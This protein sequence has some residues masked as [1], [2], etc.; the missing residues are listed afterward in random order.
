MILVS[1]WGMPV[2]REPITNRFFTYQGGVPTPDSLYIGTDTNNEIF[3]LGTSTSINPDGISINKNKDG[4][5]ISSEK[6]GDSDV[7]FGK[8]QS[9]DEKEEWIILFT[10]NDE[11]FDYF[12]F[13]IWRDDMYTDRTNEAWGV[14]LYGDNQRRAELP[15]T[16][17]ATYEG[18]S[19]GLYTNADESSESAYRLYLTTSDIS[20]EVDFLNDSALL[21]S[22]NTIGFDFDD[23][24]ASI[25][26]SELDFTDA[27]LFRDG[28]AS[29]RWQEGQCLMTAFCAYGGLSMSYYGEEFDNAEIGGRWF[30][31][32]DTNENSE[33]L[34]NSQYIAVFGAD[35][36]N[37]TP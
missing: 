2:L 19:R 32:A 36:I 29:Y 31:N 34:P 6:I 26:L 13:G 33:R 5:T 20:I 30:F 11:Q 35:L 25:S 14:M 28:T 10:D 17:S 3:Y 15:S 37:Y 1:G 23:L 21:D 16:G 7:L 8:D 9:I 12:Q 24:T 22:I 27:S 18:H 4:Q